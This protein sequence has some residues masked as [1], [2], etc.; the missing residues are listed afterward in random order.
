MWMGTLIYDSA[1]EGLSKSWTEVTKHAA[2]LLRLILNSVVFVADR[3][4]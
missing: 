4:P 1:A 3:H 2:G